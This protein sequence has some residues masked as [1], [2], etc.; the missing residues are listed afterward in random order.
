MDAVE[1]KLSSGI[2]DLVGEMIK[3]YPKLK[4]PLARF[5]RS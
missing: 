4:K 5:G 3:P 1:E 2:E